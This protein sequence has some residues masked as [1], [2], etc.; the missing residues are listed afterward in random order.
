MGIGLQKWIYQAK[1]RKY[2]SRDRKNQGSDTADN[3]HFYADKSKHFVSRDALDEAKKE[4][5]LFQRKLLIWFFVAI[6]LFCL[7]MI[8]RNLFWLEQ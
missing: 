6:A 1:P 5:R 3:A 2:F 7:F 4:Y 8:A